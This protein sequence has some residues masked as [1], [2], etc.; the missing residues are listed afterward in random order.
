MSL[1]F[2]LFVAGML[3]ILLP[4]ILPLIPIVLGVSI[5]GKS[6]WRPLLSIMGMVVSFVGFTFLL[7]IVLRQ[8]VEV[9]DYMRIG[10]YYV[11]LLF[12]LGFLTHSRPIQLGGA[13]A[14]AL[15]F[16]AKG[17][18]AVAIAA[19]LGI[20]A[21][22]I[23]GKI[24]TRIQQTGADVQNLTR[25]GLGEDSPI[26]AFII[27]LT[28]GLVW[29]PCAGP[30]LGFVFTLV[31]EQPGVQAFAYL[32]VYGLGAAVP[33]LLIGYGG[34]AAVHSVRALSKYSGYIKQFSGAVLILTA[35]A[36]QLHWFTRVETWF[37]L[38]TSYGTLGTRL[39]E[40]IFG[41][42]IALPEEEMVEKEEGNTEEP[43][44]M[45]LP[46]LPVIAPAP[47]L[48]DTGAWH[49]SEPLTIEGLKGKVVLVDF[50]TYSCI[51]CIRTFPYMRDY[52]EKYKD[53]PFV[54]LGVH[55]PEFVFEKSE[56]NVADA[57]ERNNLAYPIVQDNDY[58]TWR[59]FA[60]RYWPAKYLIDAKGNIR[61]THFGEGEYEETD[62]AIQTLLAEIGVEPMGSDI[63]SEEQV[64][65]S[66]TS[67]TYLGT[68][69]WSMLGNGAIIPG[70][71]I[72]SYTVPEELKDDHYYLEG[73]WQ[74]EDQEKQVLRSDE[75]AMY[76]RFTGSEINLVMGMEEGAAPAQVTVEIDGETSSEFTIEYN[77]LFSLWKGEYGTYELAIH[78]SGKGAEGYA[79]TFGAG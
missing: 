15:F 71:D 51:N 27:G 40:K 29:V 21:M 53:K 33:L 60:N 5:A 66:R 62:L 1:A 68:R 48:I 14:G 76:I 39:E 61:Y 77:D 12:G 18:A 75:G 2:T 16:M 35:L 28:M 24:A 20:A 69:S 46:L 45:N 6:K 78:I 30:A 58:G 55:T 57:I 17:S 65:L 38:N 49:N 11:L 13:V 67:E 42:S 43:V 70:E 34:Q 31:R 32:T 72:V 7:L 9:A 44:Q 25:E 56:Q 19:V 4:C 54:L 74:L 8:F 10:T 3:T 22:L 64:P 79:F 47:E 59:A 23:G 36:F 41:D 50:W 63:Q 73:D 52:W 37:V 26:T